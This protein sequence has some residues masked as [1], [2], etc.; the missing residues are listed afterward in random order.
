MTPFDFKSYF[1]SRDI[2]FRESGKNIGKGWIALPECTFCGKGNFH[3]AVNQKTGKVNCWVCG[4]HSVTDFIKSI[5]NCT[6]KKAKQ[7]IQQFQL[8]AQEIIEIQDKKIIERPQ[9][10]SLPKSF[11]PILPQIAKDYLKKRRYDYLHLQKKYGVLWGS[12]FG[13][14][15]FR[16]I[17]PVFEDGK[18]VNWV[19]RI[20]L[21]NTSDMKYMFERDSDALVPRRELLYGLDDCKTDKAILVEGVMNCWRLGDGAVA[22]LSQSFSKAQVLKLKQRG[23]KRFWLCFDNEEGAQKRA[24][25]LEGFLSW[26]DEVNYIGLPEYAGDPD[27]LNDEDVNY[28]RRVVF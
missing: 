1:Q 25:E 17:A 11:T 7:I 14:A 4:P 26:A 13:R 27:E 2:Q 9:T 5:E 3:F 15:K 18:I 20:V 6:Y 28:I 22:M 19:G 23:L 12:E 21:D 24:R 10:Y 8:D 16:I